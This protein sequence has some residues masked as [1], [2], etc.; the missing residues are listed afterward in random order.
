MALLRLMLDADFAT[1]ITVDRNLEYQQNV[2][3]VGI[4]VIVLHA[5][6]N[7]TEDLAPLAPEIRSIL[8]TVRTGQIRHLG[9][10]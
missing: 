9:P 2:A 5:R 1:L 10:E 7:R 3:A 4:G 8:P 6:S